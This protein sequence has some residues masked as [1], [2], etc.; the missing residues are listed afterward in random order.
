MTKEISNEEFFS[1]DNVP[2]SNWFKFEKVGDAVRGTLIAVSEKPASG[3]FAAQKVYE[4]LLKDGDTMNVGISV[5]K[6]FII[7]KMKKAIVGQ[8]VGFR[9]E[10]EIPSTTKG[11]NATKS[12]MPYVITD[13]KTGQPVLD[14]DWLATQDFG[15]EDAVTDTAPFK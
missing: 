1:E 10:K 12:I 6:D 7:Q 8:L 9:F 13:K 11:F 15:E 3:Q 14:E 2:E 5:K 4:L